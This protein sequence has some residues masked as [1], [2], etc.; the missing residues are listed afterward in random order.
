MRLDM[1]IQVGVPAGAMIDDGAASVPDIVVARLG[2]AGPSTML[3][4]HAHVV[5]TAEASVADVFADAGGEQEKRPV[6]EG[7]GKKAPDGVMPVQGASCI[8]ASGGLETP[9]V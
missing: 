5:R 9:T 8:C 3:R 6:G 7:V 1:V 2:H 4:V